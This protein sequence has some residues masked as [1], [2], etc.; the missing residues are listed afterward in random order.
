VT[1]PRTFL[2][3][4]RSDT[5]GG[6]AIELGL[7]LPVFGMLLFG[8]IDASQLIGA[9]SG[10]HYAVEEAARCSAVNT[11]LCGSDGATNNYAR[12]RYQGPNI[13]PAFTT[14]STTCGKQ[15]NATATFRLNIAVA[16]LDVPIS[17]QACYPAS[18]A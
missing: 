6:A 15:V 5:N 8:A 11:T 14:S 1:R 7:A 13:A 10:M 3:R 2:R 18:G 9:I 16:V 4:L 17:A 12:D